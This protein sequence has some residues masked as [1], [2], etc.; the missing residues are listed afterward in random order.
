MYLKRYLYAVLAAYRLRDDDSILAVCPLTRAVSLKQRVNDGRFERRARRAVIYN[1]R[2]VLIKRVAAI[3]IIRVNR[4]LRLVTLDIGRV[5]AEYVLL[6][7][8]VRIQLNRILFKVFTQSDIINGSAVK[9]R[10]DI[11]RKIFALYF[12]IW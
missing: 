6:G 11:V 1:R 4:A 8:R 5:L 7:L 12:L 10:I 3:G 2:K 9:R